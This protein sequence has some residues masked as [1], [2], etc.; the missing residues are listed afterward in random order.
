MNN[1]TI[2]ALVVLFALFIIICFIAFMWG[3]LYLNKKYGEK[4]LAARR[5][6]T[7]PDTF[8]LK[9][10]KGTFV[11]GIINF[12]LFIGVFLAFGFLLSIADPIKLN[13]PFV[14]AATAFGIAILYEF[15]G[16][17][18]SIVGFAARRLE[19]NKQQLKYRN[20]IGRTVTFHA[21]DII[22]YRTFWVGGFFCGDLLHFINSNGKKRFACIYLSQYSRILLTRYLDNQ[23]IYK[24]TK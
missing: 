6:P 15:L 12:G 23:G 18:F 4:L 11:I 19:I 17:V 24:H 9:S 21:S 1:N 7:I 14:L 16:T 20:W 13:I 8:V 2:I 22:S 3:L 10:S 5:A